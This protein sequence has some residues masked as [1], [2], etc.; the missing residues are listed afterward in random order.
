MTNRK[1]LDL[2]VD[3]SFIYGFDNDM[4]TEMFKF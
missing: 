3:L 4:K 2:C 1:G